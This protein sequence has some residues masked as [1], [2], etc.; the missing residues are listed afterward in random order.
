[1]S[2]ADFPSLKETVEDQPEL[3]GNAV[4]KA[5]EVAHATNQWALADDTG[6]EVH[7]LHGAPGVFSARYSG[8]G[9]TYESNCRKLLFE[10][11]DISDENRTAQFRTVI[12]LKTHDALY[13]VEGIIAGRIIREFRGTQGF[14]YDPIFETESGKTLAELTIAEKNKLSHRARA[15]ERVVELLQSMKYEV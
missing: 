15:L 7:A 3:Y 8:P 9:A 1:M 10:L 11:R 6:L 4:K 13:A 2:L 5:L 12:A 14:G